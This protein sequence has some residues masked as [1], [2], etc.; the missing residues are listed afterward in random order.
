MDSQ[1]YYDGDFWYA[2]QRTAPGESPATHPQKWVRVR[3]PARF[4]RVL[5]L[6]M[7]ARLHQAEG[8]FDKA[9]AV[10]RQAEV[11]LDELRTTVNLRTG[12]QPQATMIYP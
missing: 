12:R 3:I 10:D 4:A 2:V 9:L 6:K 11:W 8:Q 1:C 7:L 5:G